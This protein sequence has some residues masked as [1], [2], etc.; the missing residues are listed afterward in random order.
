MEEEN[1][2]CDERLLQDYE[3]TGNIDGHVKHHE[4]LLC[5]NKL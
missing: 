4:N 3:I 2:I 5:L 1:D